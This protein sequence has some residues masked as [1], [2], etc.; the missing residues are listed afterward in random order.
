MLQDYDAMVQLVEDL[1]TLPNNGNCLQTPFLRY[2]YP[3]ALNRCEN[4]LLK[5]KL[6]RSQF[7]I[8]L[9]LKL[10]RRNQPGDKQKAL[11]VIE[12]FLEKEENHIP[13]MVCLCGR[14]YKDMFVESDYTDKT[15][16]K[17]AIHWYQKGFD[18]QPNE[19]AGINLA[20]LLVINGEEFSK[21]EN[22][23]HIGEVLG[24]S[25]LKSIP[26]IKFS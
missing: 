9:F 20:T 26:S 6:Y 8:F 24:F 3:F 5:I 21:S 22:L 18:V 11:Q 4:E 10:L 14:I 12:K 1:Q 17:N 25:S 13:D 23:Q 19:Y 16:L 15:A 2:L 7:T